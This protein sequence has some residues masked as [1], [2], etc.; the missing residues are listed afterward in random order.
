MHKLLYGQAGSENLH[1]A[2]FILEP[3]GQSFNSSIKFWKKSDST[4]F[5]LDWVSWTFYNTRPCIYH[6]P[7]FP[8]GAP[9][10]VFHHS[11]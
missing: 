1:L 9:F 5:R 4:N 11:D 3:S 6:L 8:N 2:D 10:T 7:K